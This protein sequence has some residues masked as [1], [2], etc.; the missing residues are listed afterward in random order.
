M[1]K[2]TVPNTPPS[3]AA[4]D[5]R[6]PQTPA[7]A[8]YV[9]AHDFG[10]PA[11]TS[12]AT[13]ALARSH[14][15]ALK[16]GRR[17]WITLGAIGALVLLLGGGGVF[18]YAQYSAPGG[19]AARFCGDLKI[20]DYQ[21]AYGLLSARLHTHLG[22]DQFVQDAQALDT[23]EGKVRACGQVS[24]SDAYRY[25][26]FGSTATVNV[27]IGRSA[28]WQG[29]MSL[30]SESGDWKVDAL[31]TSLL[32]VNLGVLQTLRDFCTA[33][34][35]QD[36]S[37]AYTLLDSRLQ[38]AATQDEFSQLLKDH[39]GVDGTV[40]VCGLSGVDLGNTDSSA[41]LTASI[42]RSKLG[43]RQGPITL[44]TAGGVWK[45]TSIAEALQGTD[46]GSVQVATQL[47]VDLAIGDFTD[48]YIG[49]TSSTFQA[50]VTQAQFTAFFELPAGDSYIG[51]NLDLTTFTLSGATASF[52]VTF[53]IKVEATGQTGEVV[54]KVTFVQENGAWKILRVETQG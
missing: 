29:S 54:A 53:Q 42:T 22:E 13:F 6:P 11:G 3:F 21:A 8:Q 34:Q 28:V 19:A 36:Y 27:A 26:L 14:T 50:A 37:G 43:Q 38:A 40:S 24:G 32:G 33:L 30:R 15:P 2:P 48:A 12:P 41:Q 46:L 25:S 1:S 4:G 5:S 51:C 49:L 47:C 39:D 16:A 31:A 23:A 7:A 35:R 44:A 20:Q 10:V 9:P 18:L 52:N 17:L 45:I